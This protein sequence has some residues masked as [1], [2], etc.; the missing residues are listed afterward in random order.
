MVKVVRGIISSLKRE[1]EI[2]HFLLDLLLFY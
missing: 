1:E 2:I